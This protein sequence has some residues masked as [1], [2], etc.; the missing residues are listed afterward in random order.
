[1]H[2]TTTYRKLVHRVVAQLFIDNPHNYP[3]INHKD[4]DKA[5]NNVNNLEWATYSM[6]TQ[7]ANENG[8]IGSIKCIILDLETGIYYNTM[9]ELSFV[10]NKNKGYISELMKKNNLHKRYIIVDKNHTKNYEKPY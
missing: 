3:I 5:N 1:M 4:L 7:H 8:L 10:L 2:P 9:R 6:N